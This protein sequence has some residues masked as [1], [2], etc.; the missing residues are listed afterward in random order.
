MGDRKD[1][2]IYLYQLRTKMGL[3][4]RVVADKLGID[5]TLLSKIEL[6]ERQVQS[7]ML[8]GMAELFD[9]D[10]RA[11]QIEFLNKRIAEEYGNEPFFRESLEYY[12]NTSK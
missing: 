6:G 10:Y 7:Y 5:I 9:L 3:S 8:S 2:G 11:L 12:L 1:F 4:F